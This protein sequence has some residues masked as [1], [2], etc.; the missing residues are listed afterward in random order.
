MRQLDRFS[1]AFDAVLCM[2]QS[3]GH[4]DATTNDDVLAQMTRRL[5]NGGRL[6]LDVY[7]RPCFEQRL[8]IRSFVCNGAKVTE[9][10][11]MS[12][13]RLHVALDYDSGEHDE[14]EWQLFTPESLT[15]LA[16]MHG[17]RRITTC[18]GAHESRSPS[19]H[20]SRM[21]LVFER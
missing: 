6:V 4:F 12:G 9:A 18:T 14:F 11:R 1:D 8:G 19:A 5:T 10:K 2:W 3:F 15:E 13:D 7:H 20:A 16:E 21:Q 17:L